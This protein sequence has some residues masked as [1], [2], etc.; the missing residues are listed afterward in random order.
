MDAADV[1]AEPSFLYSNRSFWYPQAPVTDYA[2]ATHAHHRARRARLRGQ[3]RRWPVRPRAPGG[4]GSGRITE[5]CTSSG[6]HSRSGI[7]HARQP[8]RARRRRDV[9]FDRDRRRAGDGALP[10]MAGP[11]NHSLESALSRPT[12]G[13]RS[14]GASIADRA[15]DIAQFY[16][17]D[18]RRRAVSELHAS[19]SSRA[20]CPAATA[21]RISPR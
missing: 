9:A 2:T 11:V 20:I 8:L 1:S 4:E 21:R 10:P 12:R 17:V 5:G 13:R 15:V 6:R 3:R 16:A 19:R 7:W 14:A 18:R